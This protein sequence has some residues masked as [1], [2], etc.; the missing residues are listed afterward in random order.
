MYTIVARVHNRE[1]PTVQS[2]V[3][4]DSMKYSRIFTLFIEY[5]FNTHVIDVNNCL[6]MYMLSI[7]YSIMEG[8]GRHA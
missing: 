5:S 1:C 6:D 3:Q 4:T 8:D 2:A 7:K